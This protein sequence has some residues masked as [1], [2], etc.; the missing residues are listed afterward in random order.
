MTYELL[1]RAAQVHSVLCVIRH[2]HTTNHSHH[3]TTMFFPNYYHVTKPN[4]PQSLPCGSPQIPPSSPTP[5]VWLIPN[6]PVLSNPCRVAY[7][8]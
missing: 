7:P 5:T 2:L 8:R 3:V 6:T 1:V 4:F